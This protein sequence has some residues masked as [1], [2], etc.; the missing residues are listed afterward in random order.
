MGHPRHPQ[1]R[2]RPA[3]PRRAERRERDAPTRRR[4]PAAGA[5]QQLCPVRSAAPSRIEPQLVGAR[6]QG[7]LLRKRD[8]IS[9]ARVR[10]ADGTRCCLPQG[11]GYR[12]LRSK[13]VMDVGGALRGTAAACPA[14]KQLLGWTHVRTFSSPSSTTFSSQRNMP[15][16]RRPTTASSARR[17]RTCRCAD[18]WSA[19]ASWTTRSASTRTTPPPWAP[20]RATDVRP[21]AALRPFSNQPYVTRPPGRSVAIA[22][23]P[24]AQLQR[25]QARRRRV[26]AARAWALLCGVRMCHANKLCLPLLKKPQERLPEPAV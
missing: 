1:A 26:M 5:T 24:T 10:L 18:G 15:S 20:T 11:F 17:R 9:G 25:R 14:V 12:W 7:G 8:T 22:W 13:D 4:H 19:T 3:T 23:R 21:A 6:A 2:R 16:A